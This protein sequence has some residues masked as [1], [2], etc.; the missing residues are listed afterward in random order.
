MAGVAGGTC[1]GLHVA[2][3]PKST[4][5]LPNSILVTSKADVGV[6]PVPPE[7]VDAESWSLLAEPKKKSRPDVASVAEPATIPESAAPPTANWKDAR[8]S[9]R[10]IS[11]VAESERGMSDWTRQGSCP[12]AIG[13]LAR[14]TAPR[15]ASRTCPSDEATTVEVEEDGGGDAW[16]MLCGELGAE[17]DVGVLKAVESMPGELEDRAEVSEGMLGGDGEEGRTRE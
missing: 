9:L 8:W 6:A 7:I 14:S 12:I 4:E 11:E 13:A 2:A 15:A 1:D 3:V 17:P 10:L 16:W 5:S